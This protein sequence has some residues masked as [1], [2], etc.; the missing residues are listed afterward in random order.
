M[1]EPHVLVIYMQNKKHISVYETMWFS[2]LYKV[3]HVKIRS[4]ERFSSHPHVVQSQSPATDF[5]EV[6]SFFISL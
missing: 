1:I 5:E 3:A 6:S 2:E 4:C